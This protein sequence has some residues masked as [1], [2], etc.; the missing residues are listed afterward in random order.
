MQQ[1]FLFAKRFEKYTKNTDL[2]IAI[3]VL[4]II[5][6]MII[7]LPALVIDVA[8]TFSLAI[9]LLIL[10]TSIYVTRTLDFTSF[11]SL[12]LMTTLFRL[13][14]NVS[15]TRL[16]L[17]HG[18]E[19]PAAAGGVIQAFANV[20]VGN[21]YVIG[22]II[23]A[24]LVVIN[25][26]VITKGSGRV[27]EVAARFTLDAMP[28]KQMSID[29]ELNAGAINE[30]EARKRRREVEQEADFYGAMDGASK[31]VRGDAIAGILILV[32]NI[33]GGLLIGVMQKGL[34]VATAAKYY[35][36]LTIGDGLMGQI[37]A[38]I[39]STAAGIIVTRSSSG[40]NMGAEV[41]GQLFVNP[42]AIYI[43]GG[44]L[45]VLAIIPGLPT[46]PFLIMGAG[47][48]SF[49]WIVAQYKVEAIQNE[50]KKAEEQLTAPKKESVESMLPLDM[51]EL[52]VGYG[53]IN[54]VDSSKSGDLLE[55]I[56]S[57][58]KQ[59]ALDLG[60]VVPSVHI[61]D[62]LQLAP[63]EYRFLIKGNKIGGGVLRPDALLAMD[64]GQVTEQVDGIPTKEPAFGL[65][66]MWISAINRE[67]AE[68]AGYTVVDLPTVMATHITEMIRTHAHELLGRQEASQLIENFKKTHPKVVDE[69]IPDQLSLGGVVKVMQNL[70]KE[71]VSI[72]NLLT[73]FET[74]ADEAGRTKDLDLLTEAVRKQLSRS[75]TS[76][77]T[78]EDGSV[79]V[80][81]LDA[82][83][84]E[85][86]A[87]ALLQTEQGV[88]LVM[89]PQSAS[90]MISNIAQQIEN[91]PEIASQP[92]LLTS[93][94]VRRHIFKLVSRFIPQL[95][96]LS[97]N[98]V[99]A[100][101][102]VQSVASV[103]LN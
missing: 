22:F 72:R 25:F 35:S 70:L 6:V 45:A 74:L 34:D 61:R 36:M 95:I 40:E 84:E 75:I 30:T 44:V 21:N 54:V 29:A 52:E 37:P 82:R 58:R 41:T 23:F 48:V 77:Y 81:T 66:A 31:F 20:I 55:R 93:P 15:T 59:F 78:S 4:V 89:D 97:H 19:G 99:T 32:I 87:N 7:P 43:T 100:D 80:M 102:K 76:K 56:S 92:I 42:R 26:I 14:L 67:K 47:L 53:L 51:V 60:I 18:H 5:A 63:G 57:V 79:T 28:G 3:G 27:A 83:L 101:V 103:G 13:A 65:D 50:K 64:P 33:V 39:I 73:I 24:I 90:R 11:P 2:F 91:H 96:V 88:Q 94:T 10:L 69:L 98:E 49:G 38:L 62:N 85:L 46:L 8:L 12:L 68:L 17:S 9:S 71:Q 86:V 1:L 16:I